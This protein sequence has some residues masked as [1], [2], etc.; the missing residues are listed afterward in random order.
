MSPTLKYILRSFSTSKAREE[1]EKMAFQG[2]R[3]RN[4]EEYMSSV[5]V[6][7][8]RKDGYFRTAI[9]YG[10]TPVVVR[11]IMDNTIDVSEDHLELALINKRDLIFDLLATALGESKIDPLY[12]HLA[13][14]EACVK[15]AMLLVTKYNA[16]VNTLVSYSLIIQF[17]ELRM[18]K[19]TH[20]FTLQCRKDYVTWQPFYYLK[21][22]L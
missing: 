22:L 11:M 6:D 16:E 3:Y 12:M 4:V 15:M 18:K 7:A 20:H 10:I 14:K 8:A 19:K 17:T 21:V 2:H 9:E 1:F 13:A 5:T